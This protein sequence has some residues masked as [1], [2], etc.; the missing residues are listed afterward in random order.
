MNY[1][2]QAHPTWRCPRVHFADITPAMLRL[3]DGS[4]SR[5]VLTTISLTGGLLH[6]NNALERGSRINLLF[7]TPAGPVLG[8]AEM[9]KAISRSEQP[10]RF[11]SLEEEHQ[12]RLRSAIQSEL[13]PVEQAW[14][15]KYRETMV[16]RSPS[17]G[18]RFAAT[19]GVVALVALCLGGVFCLF[20]S[21]LLK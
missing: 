8:K 20:S 17:R 21:Q 6:L 2:A 5:G 9:L 13:Q 1:V 4:G 11:L 18:K 16:Q 12:R 3:P 7:V 14:I 19:L 15:K 10:F